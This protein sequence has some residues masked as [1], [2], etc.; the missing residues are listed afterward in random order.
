[1]HTL[2][3]FVLIPIVFVGVVATSAE[4]RIWTDRTGRQI[5]ADFLGFA[6]GNVRIK[7]PSDGKTF[8]V[9]LERFSDAD[10]A[11]VRAQE[12]GDNPTS[13]KQPEKSVLFVAIKFSPFERGSVD[14]SA[15][16]LPNVLGPLTRND[17]T[18]VLDKKFIKDERDRNEDYPNSDLIDYLKACV[19]QDTLRPKG[20]KGWKYEPWGT[21]QR[22]NNVMVGDS[23]DYPNAA[24]LRFDVKW[25]R[26]PAY[27]SA[28]GPYAGTDIGRPYAPDILITYEAGKKAVW[29]KKLASSFPSSARAVTEVQVG[30]SA[31]IRKFLSTLKPA[32]IA[33]K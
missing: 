12:S 20:V 18:V 28:S 25:V 27:R 11:F 9:P 2:A 5:E 3:C 14:P 4:A 21:A 33:N 30:A 29:Q 23:R 17:F 32:N 7:R 8:L 26:G 1:M 31:D 15:S 13:E 22:N 10:Q 16:F 19:D 6:N 24:I